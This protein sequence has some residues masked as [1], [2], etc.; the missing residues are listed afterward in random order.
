MLS[1]EPFLRECLSATGSVERLRATWPVTLPR[2]L[3]LVHAAST[4]AAASAAGGL[5]SSVKADLL[6]ASQQVP[7]YQLL[8]VS[9]FTLHAFAGPTP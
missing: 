4:P 9:A 6:S 2:G 3:Q 7:I 8:E 1:P 5:C